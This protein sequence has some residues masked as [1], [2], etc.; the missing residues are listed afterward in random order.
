MRFGHVR[1]ARFVRKLLSYLLSWN[2]A[3]LGNYRQ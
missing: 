1:R 3:R 2:L